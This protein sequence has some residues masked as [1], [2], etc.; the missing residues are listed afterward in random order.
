MCDINSDLI[1]QGN[2]KLLWQMRENILDFVRSVV[3][4]SKYVN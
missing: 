1:A 3:H 4:F 2:E